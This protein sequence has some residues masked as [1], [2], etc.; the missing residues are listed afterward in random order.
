MSVPTHEGVAM[1]IEGEYGDEARLEK[2]CPRCDQYRPAGL[3]GRL[4]S[5]AMRFRHDDADPAYCPDCGNPLDERARRSDDLKAF[6]PCHSCGESISLMCR[7]C[8]FC[9]KR[10][11]AFE[12]GTIHLCRCPNCSPVDDIDD[13]IQTKQYVRYCSSCAAEIQHVDVPYVGCPCGHN[14]KPWQ[15]FCEQCRTTN[16]RYKSP[17]EILRIFDADS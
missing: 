12:Y 11:D 9:G 1:S 16:S 3:L 4:R 13:L 2:F 14:L 10:N 5:L 15:R 17:A 6:Y 7:H 8:M